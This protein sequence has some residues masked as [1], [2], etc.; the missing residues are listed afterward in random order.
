VRVPLS[1]LQEFVDPQLSAE[2]LAD[3]LTMGG[4]AVEAIERPTAEVRGVV[5]AEVLDVAKIEG[6]D[7][8]HLVHVTDGTDTH[9]IVCGASNYAPG[10]RVPA[11]LP[12]SVLP[13]G[14]E[15][16]RRKVFGHTSG[17]ML[18]SA[19]EL[20][21]GD[22]HAGIWVLDDDAPVGA[23]LT[24]WLGLD[25]AVLEI[26][27]TPDRGYG[28]SIIGVARDVAALTGA[29]LREPSVPEHP[30]GDTGVPITI[31]DPARCLRFDSRRI[32]G[33]RVGPSPA[34]VQR[35]LA[36]AGMRSISGIVDA[37]N[38]AMLETGHPAH[39][40]DLDL[41]AGPRIDVRMAADGEPFTTLD[42]VERSADPDDLVIADGEGIIGFAGVMGGER[43]EVNDATTT[44]L[45]EVA[46]FAAT[47]VLRTA[48]RH[49]LLSE[50]SK[51]FEKTVPDETVPYGA[52]RCAELI[53]ALA[54]GR[55]VAH[56]DTHPGVHP[57]PTI[58]LRPARTRSVL[59][60][61]I[62]AEQQRALLERIGCEIDGSGE[63]ALTVTPPSY[64]PDLLIEADLHEEIARLHGYEAVPETVPSTGQAGG[65]TP[66]GDAQR[67]VR[68]ALAGAGW[69]E[70]LS[71]PFKATDDVEALGLPD[72]DG[73]RETIALVNPLSKEE[74]VLRTTLLPGLLRI[75][76]RNVN[77]Q[78]ADVF[79]F[80]VGHVFVPPTAEDPGAPAGPPATADAAEA[81][82]DVTL[83]AE[84]LMLGFAAS[85]AAQP[86][87]HD[88]PARAVDLHDLLGA[89]DVLRRTL[90][91]PELEVTA[92]AQ[93]PYHPGRAA[94]LRLEG[95]D[96]GV[97]GELHP[98]VAAAFEVP[99]RTLAG[100]LRLDRLVAGG[101]RPPTGRT[102]STLPGARFDVAVIVP[103]AT[104]AGAVEST[105][106]EAAGDRLESCQL[107]DV[108]E[109]EQVGEGNKSLAY[110]LVLT[111]PDEQLTDADV[112]AAIERIEA[113]AREQLGG[114]LRR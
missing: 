3:V 49:H 46:S 13:G 57:R 88:A 69:A 76:R 66:E 73:R 107:F 60:L 9:E 43:T 80:E 113:A 15:I 72:G 1:W 22:D 28:L 4:L 74:S 18:A 51:R 79:L 86:R 112:T 44:V 90:G 12:G 70:V 81:A 65:R 63:A 21:V 94:R 83:P 55:V 37:T 52:A 97:V 54:G 104:P 93:A 50:A 38:L 61:A 87:R 34:W 92:T 47:S 5:V 98:R 10:D 100:E 108:F 102:P 19:R 17:G 89:V 25:D 67:A 33:V 48:R 45:L 39:A 31:A 77:R 111:D 36:A 20:G 95:R 7:K 82:A 56:A 110:A 103:I 59:G 11:A 71:L 84:P 101:A 8:L 105:V 85:G 96:V 40:Y 75:V 106:R 58:T 26:D 23:D 2:E 68:R 24:E 62:E 64:R 78:L 6:S 14:F 16:G 30:S 41:L 27:V 99:A 91:L 109:G 114:R 42:G 35:R 32:E 29:P 53:T